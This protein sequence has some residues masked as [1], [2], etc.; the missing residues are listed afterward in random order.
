MV[1]DFHGEFSKK[2]EKL[3]KKEKIDL[4]VSNGDFFPFH[5]RKLW[6]KH[7]YGTSNELWEVIGKNN[8]KKLVLTDLKDGENAISKINDLPIPAITVY[9]NID[10]TRTM[11]FADYKIDKNHHW[12]WDEQNFFSKIIKKY[13]NINDFTYSYYAFGDYVFIGAYGGM[14]PGKPRSKNFIKHKKILE[15]LFN[16]FK[17]ENKNRK[18]IFVSH[19]VP[20]NTKLDKIGR[21]A[22]KLVRGKHYGSMMVRQVINKYQPV[23]HF[24]GHIHESKGIQK[25]GKTLCINPGAAHDGRGAIVEIV[26]NR[27]KVKLIK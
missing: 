1:G 17:K 12:K 11:D 26:N 15:K 9:G 13:K 24:G 18:V 23:I 27:V 14:V 5:Y 21:K 25:I 16:K 8:Y 20:Y 3:I 10:Y 7:C 6:F 19:N 22:H 2:F 4:L